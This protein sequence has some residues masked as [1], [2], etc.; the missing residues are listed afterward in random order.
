MSRKSPLT[1]THLNI[2]V[3]EQAVIASC[4]LL[5]LFGTIRAAWKVKRTSSQVKD[6]A[7]GVVSKI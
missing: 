3:A 7:Q 1:E 2:L 4:A 5:T 6:V